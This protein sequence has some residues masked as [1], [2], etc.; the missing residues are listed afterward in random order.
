MYYVNHLHAHLRYKHTSEYR[1]TFTCILTSAY[2]KILIIQFYILLIL[3][4]FSVI[5]DEIGAG[6][7]IN[8]MISLHCET[9][10]PIRYSKVVY[11]ALHF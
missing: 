2:S 9:K 7:L 4:V 8:R 5:D 11:S 3:L 6:Q 10:D 1:C